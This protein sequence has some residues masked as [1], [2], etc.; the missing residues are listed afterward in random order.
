M[1]SDE[2]QR[3]RRLMSEGSSEQYHP[4]AFISH[5]T[6]DH[7]FVEK[8]AADLRAN[9]VDAWFSKWEIKPGDS[10]RA[11]IEEGLEGCEYFI[12]VLSKN[13]INRPWVQTEL[14]AAT[15]RKL[16]G[17]VR[18][19]IPVRIEDCGDLPPTLGALLW[20]DFSNQPYEAAL[21][22]VLYSI[23]DVD[24]KPRLGSPPT[25]ATSDLWK[26]Q[27]TTLSGEREPIP[28]LSKRASASTSFPIH[29]NALGAFVK[30]LKNEGFDARSD[31]FNGQ[32]GLIVGPKGLEPERMNPGEAALFFP[33]WE[34][35]YEANRPLVAARRFHDIVK[36]RPSDW[37]FNKPYHQREA[38]NGSEATP[39]TEARLTGPNDLDL[40]L[41]NFHS[42]EGKH[43]I[44][45][46]LHNRQAANVSNCRIVV[47]DVRSFDSAK[48]LFRASAGFKPVRVLAENCAAGFESRNVWFLR[49]EAAH[50]E[51]G[52]T[53]NEGVM[54]WP[55]GDKNQREK[56]R[57]S[58]S[59]T[60]DGV[61][62]W[63]PELEVEWQRHAE[64]VQVHVV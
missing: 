8:F 21:K 35:N 22:R 25:I 64:T 33:L 32:V 11:K 57:V 7:P 17:K 6:L 46:R 48:V 29:M 58:L 45:A 60:A 26:F 24:T 63:K 40:I 41:E 16:S 2:L 39:A 12:I 38:Q 47:Q 61:D 37:Q 15:I 18:K 54:N 51:I 42:P 49:I 19:I 9:G 4:K 59:M 62:E 34:L 3:V 28:E 44:L 13:S 43:G 53:I 27:I 20:E 50:L 1:T 55:T 36:N 56:W 10:I 5:A 23:F 30:D 31:L 14:D 52:D